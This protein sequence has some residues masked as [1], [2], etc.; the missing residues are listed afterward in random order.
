MNTPVVCWFFIALHFGLF[1]HTLKTGDY[2][3]AAF[4]SVCV[5]WNSYYLVVMA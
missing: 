4:N 3:W 5:A 1:I 2:G